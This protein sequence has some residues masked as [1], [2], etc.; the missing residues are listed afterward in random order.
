MLSSIDWYQLEL[1]STVFKWHNFNMEYAHKHFTIE[2]E[3][4]CQTYRCDVSSIAWQ[5]L[6]KASILV[7]ASNCCTTQVKEI[8]FLKEIGSTPQL[9]DSTIAVILAED[10][11]I[12]HFRVHVCLPFKASLIAKFFL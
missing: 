11:R 7:I 5:G 1:G 12:S 2:N 3:G 4:I 6:S 10:E 8:L 9:L